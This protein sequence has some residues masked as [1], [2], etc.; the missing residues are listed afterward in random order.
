MNPTKHTKFNFLKHLDDQKDRN[1]EIDLPFMRKVLETKL[2][3][4]PSNRSYKSL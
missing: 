3:Q 4:W 2:R 1:K